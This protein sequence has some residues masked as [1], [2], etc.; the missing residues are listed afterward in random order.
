MATHSEEHLPLPK[1]L[2]LFNER[3][4]CLPA[5]AA[6]EQCLSGA[7][8]KASGTRHMPATSD[9]VCTSTATREALSC[10]KQQNGPR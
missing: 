7:P 10:A 8:L 1:L 3:I 9:I 6:A 4:P 2:Q 5:G